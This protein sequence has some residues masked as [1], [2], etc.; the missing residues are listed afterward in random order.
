M[1]ATVA[2]KITG[3]ELIPEIQMLSS[4]TILDLKKRIEA[5][6]DV[7]VARQTLRFNNQV[8]PNDLK[9]NH[10]DFNIGHDRHQVVTLALVV[11]PLAE[12]KNSKS[13]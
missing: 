1:A 13:M 4:E 8:L 12:M 10:Y 6:L 3:G 2:F 7:P 11:S 5:R 9:I